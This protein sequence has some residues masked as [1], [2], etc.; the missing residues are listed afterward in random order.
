MYV[1]TRPGHSGTLAALARIAPPAL[2]EAAVSRDVMLGEIAFDHRLFA[3]LAGAQYSD[4]TK[5]HFWKYRRFRADALGEARVLAR[6]ENGDP[7]VVEKALDRGRLIVLASGWSPADSQLARSSKF[8]PLMSALLDLRDPRSV[9]GPN[10]T[11]GDRVALPSAKDPGAPIVVHKPDGV[12]VSL[13]PGSTLFAGADQ[14]GVYTIDTPDGPSPFAVN[15]DPAESRVS[16]LSIETL[17]QLG[18]R[19]VSPTRKLIDREQLRQLQNAEL[20]GRQKLWRWL[21]LLAIGVLIVETFVAGR[22]KRLRLA[23]AEAL[24]R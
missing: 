2:E 5:I 18:C 1:A 10:H 13:P 3:P 23:P 14:P 24:S 19:L 15:L 21:I 7:A 6:F 11:V 9:D 8:V 17:E 20:E 22:I 4:F 12:V 16:P